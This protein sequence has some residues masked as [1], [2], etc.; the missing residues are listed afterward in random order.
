M[1][2]K[3]IDKNQQQQVCD[4]T[5]DCLKRVETVFQIKL[6]PVTVTFDLTGRSAGMYRVQRG[7]RTIR[8]NPYLFAKYFDDNLATTVPHEVAHYAADMLYG[9]QHIRPHGAEWQAIMRALGVEPHATGRYDLT[10]IPVRRQQRFSYY[11]RCSTHQLSASRHY[12]VCRKKAA[13]FCNRCGER[14]VRS[15]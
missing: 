4:A 7:K 10:G 3:P 1:F 14:I 15:E 9:F 13:Y 12:K 5:S 2:I 6:E 11:C 8:Y